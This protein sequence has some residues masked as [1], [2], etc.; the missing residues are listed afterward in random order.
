MEKFFLLRNNFSPEK[1]NDKESELEN[2]KNGKKFFS[3][4]NQKSFMVVKDLLIFKRCCVRDVI[5]GS[6]K[7]NRIPKS[8]GTKKILLCKVICKFAFFIKLILRHLNFYT[9][10]IFYLCK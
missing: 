5:W 9:L 6:C 2:A 4:G 7:I 3:M 8:F 1:K 10:F